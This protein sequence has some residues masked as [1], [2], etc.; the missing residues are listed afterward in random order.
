MA[1]NKTY[2]VTVKQTEGSLETDLFKKMAEKGD[3]TATTAQEMTNAKITIKGMADVDVHTDE[4]DFSVTYVDTEEYGLLQA[5]TESMFIK[6]I[7]DYKEDTDSFIIKEVKCKL[8]K[9]VKAVPAF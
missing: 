5:S 9:G 1:K 7:N 3:I 2:V 8:G 4:R 6:S